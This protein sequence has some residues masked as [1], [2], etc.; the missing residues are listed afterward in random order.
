MFAHS[1]NLIFFVAGIVQAILLAGLSYFHPKSDKSVNIYLSLYILSVCIFMLLSVVQ[2]FFSW[3]I[4]L[5]LM[6]FPFL[7]GP[8]LYLYVRSF[9]ETI[10]WR[11]AW[12]HFLLFF[13]FLVLDY[14]FL[15]FF[16][17]KYP[18]AHRAPEEVLLNPA[19]DIRIII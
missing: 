3:Q 15:S 16:A 17:A 4:M 14:T 2:E 6:P 5:Y 9:K 11:K 7:I 18:A 12:P 19:G 13:M 1:A 8:F 10:T